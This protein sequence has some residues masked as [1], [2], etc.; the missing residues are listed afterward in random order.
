MGVGGFGGSAAT[1]LAAPSATAATTDSADIIGQ[2]A[3]GLGG[4]PD[5]PASF[6]GSGVSGGGGGGVRGERVS[7]EV[8][9]GLPAVETATATPPAAATP[10]IPTATT[11]AVPGREADVLVGA[12]APGGGSGGT[13]TTTTSSASGSGRIGGGGGLIGAIRGMLAAGRETFVEVGVTL[14]FCFRIIL[15]CFKKGA[16]KQG[17]VGGGV[18]QSWCVLATAKKEG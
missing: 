9:G 10:T 3:L 13:T 6:S 17:R 14:L 12:G 8:S 2:R 16:C 5:T 11:A 7:S 15:G 1:S 4:G 18:C